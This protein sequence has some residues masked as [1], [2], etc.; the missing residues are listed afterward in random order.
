MADPAEKR[1]LVEMTTSNRLAYGKDVYLE[2]S[3]WLQDV[4]N[5]LGVSVGDPGRHRDRTDPGQL[6]KL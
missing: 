4:E 3:D 6:A 1:Q 2:P 5:T